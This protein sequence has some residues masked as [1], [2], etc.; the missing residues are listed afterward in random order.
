MRPI[1]REGEPMEGKDTDMYR[2]LVGTEGADINGSGGTVI[3]AALDRVGAMGGGEVVLLPGSY[4]LYDSLRLS[5]GTVLRGSGAETVLCKSDGWEAPLWEDGDWGDWWVCCDPAPPAT[6]GEGVCVGSDAA[7]GFLSTVG[8][9][10]ETR[11]DR[12]RISRRFNMDTM[13]EDNARVA[14]VFPM[15]AV[16]SASDVTIRDLVI[17]GNRRHNSVIN[18]CRGGGVWGLFA[19]RVVVRNVTVRNFNGD[20][21]SFQQGHDWVVEECLTENNTGTGLHP[22]SGS[23]RPI[24]KQCVA[25]G[26]GGPGLFVCW[27]VK[28]GGFS[29]NTLE[30]N[31]GAGISVG[32]K[33]TDNLFCDN[34]LRRNAGP[35]IRIRRETYPMAPHRC[36][37]ERNHMFGNYN[38]GPQ[39][40][41]EGQV[42]DLLFQE[43]VYQDGGEAF[44]IA[45]EVGSISTDR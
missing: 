2:I 25:R 32:H 10:L 26:N 11:E 40:V 37:F 15:V 4:T 36:T 35:A 16:E 39:V 30:E 8:T 34:T 24:I 27:R 38:G 14:N 31:G 33:D 7:V 43:N 23:Q 21:I 5:S 17:D 29:G 42:H 9:V 1:P 28:H 18:G 13:V 20:A 3:Q 19:E 22:G 45:Q 6:V 12:F 44:R 41:V